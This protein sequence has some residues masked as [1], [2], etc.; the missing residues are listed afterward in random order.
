VRKA[1][2]EQVIASL[3]KDH[4]LRDKTISPQE[5]HKHEG[6]VDLLMA[7]AVPVSARERRLTAAFVPFQYVPVFA[8]KAFPD[9]QYAPDALAEQTHQIYDVQK[10]RSA[11]A[12][13]LKHIYGQDVDATYD[14]L[15]ETIHPETGLS[16]YFRAE[17]D[18]Q[19]VRLE[20][21]GEKPEL[22]DKEMTELLEDPSNLARYEELLPPDR[23][24][25][26]RSSR[27]HDLPTY[28][29]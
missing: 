16:R 11:Y 22:T 18:V 14:Q 10:T 25:D 26:M 7:A 5:A 21:V 19:F 20:V 29:A 17:V 2:A 12:V 27:V 8:T 3:P 23:F 13:I 1:L 4:P 15:I 28:V 6:H 9:L 24:S